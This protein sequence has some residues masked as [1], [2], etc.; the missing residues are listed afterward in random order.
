MSDTATMDPPARPKP[1]RSAKPLETSQASAPVAGRTPCVGLPVQYHTQTEIL[2]GMLQRQSKADPN[3]WDV[4]VFLGGPSVPV[5]R[6]GVKQSDEAKAGC[7]TLL[8]GW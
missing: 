7:W 5:L 8:P 1:A 2:P 4:R 3:V 6:I